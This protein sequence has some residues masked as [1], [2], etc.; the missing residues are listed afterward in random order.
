MQK[1][2]LTKVLACVLAMLMLLSTLAISTASANSYISYSEN[3]SSVD[4]TT[5]DENTSDKNWFDKL[6]SISDIKDYVEGLFA[7]K[8]ETSIS[9]YFLGLINTIPT[10]DEID[11]M[12]A[13]SPVEALSSPKKTHTKRCVSF[14]LSRWRF[15]K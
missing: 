4:E 3:T 9:D 13:S 10:N 12:K 1:Y 7:T 14:L 2:A 15:E 5:P 8:D 6:P 11:E